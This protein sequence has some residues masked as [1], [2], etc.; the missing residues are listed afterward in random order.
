MRNYH[1]SGIYINDYEEYQCDSTNAGF[2][3][4]FS[5]INLFVGVNNSGK[6]R[7]MRRVLSDTELKFLVNEI[8]SRRMYDLFQQFKSSI[9]PY[10]HL[11]HPEGADT[12]SLD[13]FLRNS[14]NY[15]KARRL[16]ETMANH[17][18][19]HG[20]TQNDEHRKVSELF[21][22]FLEEFS[23]LQ[24]DHTGTERFSTEMIYIPTLRGLRPIQAIS[25]GTTDVSF[26]SRDV[27]YERTRQDYFDND[28]KLK[29]YTGLQFYDDI[30]KYSRNQ[31]NALREVFKN[32]Q[33]FLSQTFFEG[34]TVELV[35]A[36]K[37]DVV[38][39]RIGNTEQPIYH[40]GDGIQA[41]IALTYPL[42]FNQGRSIKFFIE[43]PELHL[44]PGFQRTFIET[45]LR[46]QFNNFQYFITTHSNHFL[47][48]SLELSK[49][50]I[51]TFTKTEDQRFMIRNVENGDNNILELIG[52][53]NSSVFLTNCSIWVE[54][55]TDRLYIRKYLELF[56]TTQPVQF[57]EDIHYSFVE[58]GGN[59]I[60]HWSF[61]EDED[62]EYPNILVDRLC[63]KLFLIADSDSV[64][65]RVTS[66]KAQ[67]NRKLKE[68]LGDRYHP[69]ACREI[70]NLLSPAVLRQ[71]LQQ[72]E[73]ISVLPEY[74]KYKSLPFGDFI[75]SLP[76]VKR[77][78]ASSSGTL[79]HKADFARKII[80]FM[81]SLDDLSD[82]AKLIAEK[83]YAFILKQHKG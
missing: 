28:T 41:I 23:G 52:V 4:H 34:A 18:K 14:I 77:K 50:S 70:E 76:G 42:F 80:S 75:Q 15:S 19:G 35:P 6:S 12:L 78:Y 69:L 56:Q 48:L 37:Q 43:E 66:K 63:G 59:N 73:G 36:Y 71:F 81:K 45:L 49:I 10:L 57:K 61:L 83:L 40:L 79:L 31:D 55:I 51:Y 54:G 11:Y 33:Q 82:E 5:Q 13:P 60:T 3:D 58:Y 62:A 64:D 72:E 20:E 68:K 21:A 17:V 22:G 39:L 74:D 2:I 25:Q 9:Q 1:L 47:D 32:F 7:F 24:G 16:F 30:D 8:D 38:R 46:P 65:D 26:E 29:M 27:Y 67:R 53:R 44:H